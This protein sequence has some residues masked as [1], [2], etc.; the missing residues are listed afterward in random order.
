MTAR[1]RRITFWSLSGASAVAILIAGRAVLFPFLLAILIAFVLFPAVRATERR[2]VPRWAGIL[3]VYAA[4]IGVMVG[5]GFVVLPRLYAETRTL[6]AELPE[7]T[8]VIRDE[9]LPRF[10]RA[11]GEWLR[12][13]SGSGGGATSAAAP[14]E[15]GAPEDPDVASIPA[16]SPSAVPSSHGAAPLVVRPR[17]DGGYTI[18]L[19]EGVHVTRAD[20]QRW[21]I[22]PRP[23]PP[24]RFSSRAALRDAFDAAVGYAQDN[25][26]ELLAVGQRV[27]SGISRGIFYFG[28]TLMLAGYM[29]FT[30]EEIYA[31]ARDLFPRERHASVARFTARLDRGLSGVVR[32]QLLICLVNGILSAIG[33]WLFGLKYWPILSVIATVLSIVPIFGS[34]ISTIPA[35]V[36]GLTDGLG[37]AVGVLVWVIAIHQVEANFLNPKIIGDQAKI[38][39]VLIVFALLVGEHFFRVPGLV[40]AVPILALAQV[41]F[42][43]FREEVAPAVPV[44]PD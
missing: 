11:L 41:T 29:M 32:G 33:F 36:I 16:S 39:P 6:S 30:W 8:R 44:A 43:H 26:L 42:L 20:E 28:I 18:E 37:T 4:M 22:G 17:D 35:V 1:T 40:L 10:D 31:F 27:L 19:G 5:S 38:H 9:A 21:V 14:E 24:E 3:L 15:A 7:F 23:T 12:P 13:S 34:I 2:G 25:S